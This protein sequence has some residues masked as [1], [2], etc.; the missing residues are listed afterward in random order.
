ML[1]KAACYLVEH[2]ALLL[3]PFSLMPCPYH[4]VDIQHTKD[5]IIIVIPHT[6][7]KAQ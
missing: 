2:L 3:C 7:D 6:S 1:G 4:I 5:K